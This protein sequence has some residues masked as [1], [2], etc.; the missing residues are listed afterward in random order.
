MFKANSCVICQYS[1]TDPICRD[2]YIKET[3]I[4]L[5]DLRI[6]PMISD[7]INT[8][9]KSRLPLE[10]LNDAECI[11][12]KKDTASICRYCFSIVLLKLLREL[13]FTEEI[14]ENFGYHPLYGEDHLDFRNPELLLL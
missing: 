1:I 10:T 14:I 8:K 7:L 6:D 9:L 5:N 3:M 12:C 4:M 13:N 2:C 11:L